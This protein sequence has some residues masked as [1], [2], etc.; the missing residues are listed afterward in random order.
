MKAAVANV[1]A[2]GPAM[3]NHLDALIDAIRPAVRNA[4]VQGSDD[5]VERSARENAR[6]VAEKIRRSEPVMAGLCWKDVE[7]LPAYYELGS[8]EVQWLG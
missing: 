5:L 1:D 8:G 4:Q 2:L 3:H 7:V 6:V